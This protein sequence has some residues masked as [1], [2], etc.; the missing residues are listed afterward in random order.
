MHRNARDASRSKCGRACVVLLPHVTRCCS[1]CAL[2]SCRRDP[3]EPTLCIAVDNVVRCVTRMRLVAVMM[4][5]VVVQEIEILPRHI[6]ANM[7]VPK[8]FA[9]AHFRKERRPCLACNEQHATRNKWVLVEDC[10]AARTSVAHC[11]TCLHG[12]HLL[13]PRL[14]LTAETWTRPDFLSQATLQHVGPIPQRCAT[15]QYLSTCCRL[16]RYVATS[17]NGLRCCNM[18]CAASDLA[19]W[20]RAVYRTGSLAP[21]RSHPVGASRRRIP[22]VH[23]C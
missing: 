14:A 8:T 5:H 2:L 20:R 11:L 4:L 12:H 1:A 15:L 22:S 23:R 21:L 7:Y 9:Q 18:C 16:L 17:C 6:E 3:N 13:R 19:L 10:P